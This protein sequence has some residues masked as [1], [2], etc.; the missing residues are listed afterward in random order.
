MTEN[1]AYNE[2]LGIAVTTFND[3]RKAELE[4]AIETINTLGAEKEA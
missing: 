4:S 3:K 1:R 2:A